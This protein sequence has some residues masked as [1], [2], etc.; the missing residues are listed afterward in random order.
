MHT[1]DITGSDGT[2]VVD[3]WAEWCGPCKKVAPVL[4]ELAEETGVQLVKVNADENREIARDLQV[5]SIPTV[6]LFKDGVEVKRLVGAQ[7][8]ATY[9]EEFG[10]KA[11]LA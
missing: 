4:A 3:I 5:Q 10:L 6:I 1:S 7:S 2:I 9:L 11:A 8:K